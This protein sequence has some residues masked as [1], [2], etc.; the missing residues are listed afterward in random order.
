[1]QRIAKR[2]RQLAHSGRQF[3]HAIQHKRRTTRKTGG[4]LAGIQLQHAARAR[5]HIAEWLD[6][7][8][9]MGQ[10]KPWRAEPMLLQDSV[11]FVPAQKI[12]EAARR[13]FRGQERLVPIVRE[14]LVPR[15]RGDDMIKF[16]HRCLSARRGAAAHDSWPG[17][18]LHVPEEPAVAVNQGTM[19]KWW[20]VQGSNLWPL[21][22]QGSALP[23]S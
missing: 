11:E 9:L 13:A 21:P 16:Q 2:S 6:R 22:C 23:L 8:A 1:M 20:A 19:R 12:G 5:R 7:T 17:P 3:L 18:L 10:P 15:Q 4:E 14:E